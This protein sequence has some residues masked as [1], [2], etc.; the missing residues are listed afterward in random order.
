[1]NILLQE[2]LFNKIISNFSVSCADIYESLE[3]ALKNKP[4]ECK[5]HGI[6]RDENNASIIVMEGKDENNE[7]FTINFGK[8]YITIKKYGWDNANFILEDN[9]ESQIFKYSDSIYGGYSFGSTSHSFERL[10]VQRKDEAPYVKDDFVGDVNEIQRQCIRFY[11]FIESK[12]LSL[13]YIFSIKSGSILCGIESK[14]NNG[15][16]AI[17]SPDML[18]ERKLL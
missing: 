11:S 5:H 2:T 17:Q 8:N 13:P 7:K 4:N 6:F 9:K 14:V 12:M 18:V 3:G 10:T 16:S 1:M 15:D